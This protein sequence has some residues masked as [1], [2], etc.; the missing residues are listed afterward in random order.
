MSYLKFHLLT[1]LLLAIGVAEIYL[2]PSFVEMGTAWT[3][4]F[5][6]VGIG[7]AILLWRFLR[8]HPEGMVASVTKAILGAAAIFAAVLCLI[9]VPI[10]WLLPRVSDGFYHELSIIDGSHGASEPHVP[11]PDPWSVTGS[12]TP[13]APA[14]KVHS[15]PKPSNDAPWH[16][17]LSVAPR[18]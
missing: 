2:L 10:L 9:V 13:R 7:F 8:A 5:A 12:S 1:S 16:L 15:D 14:P 17:H 4:A 6:T 11:R 18:Q 3:I